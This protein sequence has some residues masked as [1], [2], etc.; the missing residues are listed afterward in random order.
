MS[1]AVG[2]VGN[3]RDRSGD[4]TG[5]RAQRLGRHRA[6]VAAGIL[7]HA[8]RLRWGKDRLDAE[9][10][11]A[12]R[13]LL[14]FAKEHSPYHAQRLADV[15]PAEFTEAQL[16]HLPVMTKQEMMADLSQVT[17][18]RRVTGDMVD[19]HLA[20]VDRGGD[21]YLLGQYRVIAS[22]G[23]SGFRGTYVYDWDGWT[24]LGLMASRSRM[25]MLDGSPRPPGSATVNLLGS[26]LTTLS[27][28]MSSF[29]AD[30]GDPSLHLPM[31]TPIPD[32]IAVL[33]AA[34]P[35]LLQAYPSRARPAGP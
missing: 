30:P 34:Q 18:D 7:A 25:A 27:S 11:R 16:S 3:G 14:A 9:R 17:T 15:E 23:S 10:E 19:R 20:A 31:T 13:A 24:T 32:M 28:A 5:A 12:L 6:A 21:D 26:G 33:E 2:A 29:L 1:G 22:S 35:V 4:T 8:R